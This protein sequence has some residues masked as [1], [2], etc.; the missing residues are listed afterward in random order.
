M[1]DDKQRK[2]LENIVQGNVIEGRNDIATTIRNHLCKS[3]TASNVAE[4]KFEYFQRI[5]KEQ[6]SIIAEISSYNLWWL[7]DFSN[8]YQ[9]LTEGGEAKIYLSNCGTKVL[10][11]NDAVYYNT[12]LDFFNSILLHNFYFTNT[13]YNLTGFVI[14]N[15][16]LFAIVEQ[17]YIIA[18]KLTDIDSIKTHL[19]ANGFEHKKRYDYFNKTLGISLEDIHD[20]NVLTFN[21]TLFFIDTFFSL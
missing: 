5:K 21:D 13:N 20:E 14:D 15:E 19:I 16:T 8:S 11:I 17:P 18:N 7:N 9:Y 12:W 6:A 1:Y 4:R 2:Y 3:Y 10:K